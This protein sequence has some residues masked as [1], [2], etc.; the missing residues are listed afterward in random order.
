MK[1]NDISKAVFLERPN[2]FIAHVL[3]NGKK[4]IVHVKNTG[5]R[6]EI[7]NRGTQVIL[8]KS[9]NKNRKTNYSLISA[10]KGNNL[11]NIDSQVPNAVVYQ[12]LR[13]KKVD[14]IQNICMLKREV[15]YGNSRFDIYFETPLEKGFVEV[16]GVTLEND[17]ITMFPDAPTERGTKHVKEMVKAVHE[18]YKG[19]IF[20]LI[21]MKGVKYF[22]PNAIMDDKFAS[23]LKYAKENGV[24]ILAYDSYVTENEIVIGN[25]VKVKI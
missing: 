23:A 4:E 2:R 19:Y 20:F 11:I 25:K 7:L 22:T 16:K 13:D 15:F 1:Y 6:R 14:E 12:G 18:G 21:Q 9:R 3:L 10:Y 24:G 8:E 5:R 17:G